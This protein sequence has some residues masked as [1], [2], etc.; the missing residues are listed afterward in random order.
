[1]AFKFTFWNAAYLQFWTFS[2]MKGEE[3]QKRKS[4]IIISLFNCLLL[5]HLRFDQHYYKGRLFSRFR[6]F[7]VNFLKIATP[8]PVEPTRVDFLLTK[9]PKILFISFGKFT[10]FYCIS[11]IRNLMQELCYELPNDLILIDLDKDILRKSQ[12]C[13]GTEPS[14]QSYLQK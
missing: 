10:K 11:S 8:S 3:K 2:L 4:I 5:R 12:N 14:L 6:V 7:H 9:S 1:M 13:M